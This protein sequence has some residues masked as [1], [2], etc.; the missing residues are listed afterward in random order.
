[1]NITPEQLHKILTGNY[2]FSQLGFS[3]L[4][5]R[6]KGIYDDDPSPYVLRSCTREVNSYLNRYSNI[7]G[8]DCSV[9]SNL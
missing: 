1:M 9:I 3:M 2:A 8:M 5:T 6:L 4:I 7:M